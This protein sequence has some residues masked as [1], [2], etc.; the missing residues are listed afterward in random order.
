MGFER[1]TYTINEMDGQVELCVNVTVPADQNIDDVTFSLMVD[2]RNGTASMSWS[3]RFVGRT[4]RFTKM[5]SLLLSLLT[6]TMVYPRC[7][8][9]YTT[10][11]LLL[12]H[13]CSHTH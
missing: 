13:T 3:S 8:N 4:S 1:T 11:A 5:L 9:R 6:N 7:N 10:H 2:T 12:T